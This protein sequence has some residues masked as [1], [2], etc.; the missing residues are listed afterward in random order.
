M[1]KNAKILFTR[2]GYAALEKE[3]AEYRAKRE[4]ALVK[5]QAAREQGDLSENGAY[6]AARFELSDIDRQI[7]SLSYLIKYGQIQEA[8]HDGKIG[9]G[10]T[11]TLEKDGKQI[12][13]LLVSKYESDP[14]KNKLS[15]ESPLGQA[16][17]GRKVGESITVQ[18]PVGKLIYQVVKI[19]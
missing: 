6:K 2:E 13:Y 8:Q 10:N 7:R 9:F 11:V 16:L 19:V 3:L 12:V 4:P 15:V 5:L 18:A 1:I 14:L 17:M